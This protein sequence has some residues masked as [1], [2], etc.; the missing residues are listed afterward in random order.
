MCPPRPERVAERDREVDR[1]H[2]RPQHRDA[3][4]ARGCECECSEPF[5]ARG[6]TPMSRRHALYEASRR[7]AR[8]PDR[9]SDPHTAETLA[10]SL[11]L[12]GEYDRALRELALLRRI[13]LEDEE[14]AQWWQELNKGSAEGEEDWII[15]VG[16]R[17]A[18]VQE[19]LERSPDEAVALLNRWNEEELAELRLPAKHVELEDNQSTRR[20]VT[21]LSQ[22]VRS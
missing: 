21:R 6:A 2:Q 15:T 1:E 16:K 11:I 4:L 7:L 13:T 19:A 14:R 10:Y 22:A 9:R 3:A 8:E 20:F 12:I 18:Q 17:G 5:G